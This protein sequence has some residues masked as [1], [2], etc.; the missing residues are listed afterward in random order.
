MLNWWKKEKPAKTSANAANKSVNTADAENNAEEL[1]REQ[2]FLSQKIQVDVALKSAGRNIIAVIK[3]LR[4]NL[5]LDL[6]QAKSLADSAPTVIANGMLK[7]EAIAL[8]Q[9]LRSVGAEV[10]LL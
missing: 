10:E 7:E 4:E 9:T 8:T 3:I 2:E 5:H 1:K 6:P